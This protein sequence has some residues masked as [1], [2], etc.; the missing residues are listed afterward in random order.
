[1]ADVVHTGDARPRTI[2]NTRPLARLEV[3]SKGE[4]AELASHLG[5]VPE[6]TGAGNRITVQDLL[7]ALRTD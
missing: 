7:N 6:R 4:L 1:M 3:M 5:I 2:L